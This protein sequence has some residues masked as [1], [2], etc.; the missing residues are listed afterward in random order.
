M[1]TVLPTLPDIASGNRKVEPA[2]EKTLI[3]IVAAIVITAGMIS[4]GIRA[5]EG[6]LA[7]S[8]DPIIFTQS[9][10]AFQ[11][12]PAP[13]HSPAAVPVSR[14]NKK[15]V[16]YAGRRAVGGAMRLTKPL[17]HLIFVV[18]DQQ[19]RMLPSGKEL[20]A[21]LRRGH[22]DY[23]LL[24]AWIPRS[25][26]AFFWGEPSMMLGNQKHFLGDSPKPI[27]EPGSFQVSRFPD[28]PI[29]FSWLPLYIAFT[30][31]NGWHVRL[32]ARWDDVDSYIQVPTIAFKNDV[33]K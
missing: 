15:I 28:L 27:G 10:P 4:P 5:E 23:P 3:S 32:G 13:E 24:F 1:D 29:P 20:P 18:F 7:L 12:A 22:D 25:W 33:K 6:P 16:K 14:R 11:P 17:R 9:I 8:P 31:P 26:T 30:T 19:A 2:M 21:H